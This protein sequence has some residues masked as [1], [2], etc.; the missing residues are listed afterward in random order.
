MSKKTPRE[1]RSVLERLRHRRGHLIECFL[2][3]DQGRD[4]EP[5]NTHRALRKRPTRVVKSMPERICVSRTILRLMADK[6]VQDLRETAIEVRTNPRK[7][8]LA[9]RSQLEERLPSPEKLQKSGSQHIQIALRGRCS[10]S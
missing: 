7:A 9:S 10:P 3:L 4:H 1:S 8:R 5:T 2:S 6:A